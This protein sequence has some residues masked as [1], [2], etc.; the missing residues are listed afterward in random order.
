M[1]TNA[2]ECV[3]LCNAIR[4]SVGDHADV[5]VSVCPP[6]LYL[7]DAK[8]A[9]SGSNVRVGAQNVHWEQQGAYTGEISPNMLQGLVDDVII[10]HSERRQYFGETDETVNRRLQAALAHNL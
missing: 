6:F 5:E 1:H 3:A 4:Q 10:G 8:K 9:L 2:Q 7:P